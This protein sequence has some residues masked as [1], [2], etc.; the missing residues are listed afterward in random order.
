M[1]TTPVIDLRYWC[2][3]CGSKSGEC[4]PVTGCC[5]HCGAGG[6]EP[7]PD[8]VE[9]IALE[10]DKPIPYYFDTLE[11]IEWL[12]SHPLK[13]L[14]ERIDFPPEHP[15]RKATHFILWHRYNPETK[16]L[17]ESRKDDPYNW[18]YSDYGKTSYDKKSYMD[19]EYEESWNERKLL[20]HQ[21]L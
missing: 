20:K 7:Y 19:V 9:R 17:E 4:D 8:E 6:W 1:N 18:D 13:V 11:L 10:R 21:K 5:F 16:K 14:R 12:K 15:W 2:E 3:A